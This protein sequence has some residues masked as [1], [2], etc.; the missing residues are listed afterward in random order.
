MSSQTV[1][2][3]GG[4]RSACT[5]GLHMVLLRNSDC[6]KFGK[7]LLVNWAVPGVKSGLT[8][9]YAEALRMLL[10]HN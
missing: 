9:I 8:H 4:T 5:A 6:V 2:L 1:Q 3:G 10:Q 7:Y